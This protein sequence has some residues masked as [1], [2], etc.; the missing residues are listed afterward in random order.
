MKPVVFDVPLSR[1]H[2]QKFNNVREGAAYQ[3][4]ALKLPGHGRYLSLDTLGPDFTKEG[5]IIEIGGD[6]AQVRHFARLAVTNCQIIERFEGRI[7]R[8]SKGEITVDNADKIEPDVTFTFE[9]RLPVKKKVCARVLALLPQLNDG[10]VNQVPARRLAAPAVELPK[11]HRRPNR[12][13][14]PGWTLTVNEGFASA[15]PEGVSMQDPSLV[16]I[17]GVRKLGWLFVRK[18]RIRKLTPRGLITNPQDLERSYTT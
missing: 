7:W 2:A 3:F 18:D 14:D 10:H 1:G 13:F 4:P 12:W 6:S 11:G 5:G 15:E 9:S 17:L 8:A 16:K